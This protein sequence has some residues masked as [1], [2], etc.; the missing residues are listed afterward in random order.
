MIEI[1]SVKKYFYKHGLFSRHD[2][3]TIKAV[4]DV[5]FTV[6]KGQTFGLV[7]ESGSGKSTLAKIIAGIC[8]ADSGSINLGGRLDM[9]FQDPA[10]SLNP[11][12]KAR[13]IVAEPLVVRKIQKDKI[14]ERVKEVFLMVNLEYEKSKNKYPHQF[15]GGEKQRIAIARAL[16]CMPSVL[17]LDEPV[18][19]LDV[20]VQA[21]ILNLLK[22]LQEKLAI[23]YIFISHDLRVVEFMSSIIGVMYQGKLIEIDTREEIYLYPK[24][25]YTRGLINAIPSL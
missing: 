22:D 19:S 20:L 5:S 11:C 3:E 6:E 9:V 24:T 2:K 25:D 16:A 18:S 17:I 7:G 4:D 14:E 1:K 12:F 8:Q 10:H 23:T 13:E 15:S 21:G